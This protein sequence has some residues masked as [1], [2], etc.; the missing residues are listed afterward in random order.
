MTFEA[1]TSSTV[2]GVGYGGFGCS[3][4]HSSRRHRNGGQLLRCGAELV[5]VPLRDH[6]HRR[7]RVDQPVWFLVRRPFGSADQFALVGALGAAVGD[8]RD[9][10]QAGLDRRG[11]MAEMA[12]ERRAADV[13]RI[14]EAGMQLELSREVHRRERVM[15]TGAEDAVDVG[16]RQPSVGNGAPR[17]LRHQPHRGPAFRHPGV[18]LG[19]A[20]DGRIPA[21][22]HAATT[23][24]WASVMSSVTSSN[25]TRTR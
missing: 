11:G 1:S 8:E 7:D 6:R 4:D 23:K 19:G 3:S 10:A 2:S 12:D 14:H 13:G 15:R 16:Q 22:A 25:S 9:F 21:D 17:R 5:H 24:K 20:D 18:E